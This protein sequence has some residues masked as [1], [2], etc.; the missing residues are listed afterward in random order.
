MNSLLARQLRRLGLNPATPPADPETWQRLIERI[1][2][3]YDDAEQSRYLL[4]RSLQISSREMQDLYEALQR[5]SAAHADEQEHRL[6]AVFDSLSDG[7]CTLDLGGRVEFANA[8]AAWMLGAPQ[9]D[10]IGRG[11]LDAFTFHAG[12][13]GA[14]PA[15]VLRTVAAGDRFLDDTALLSTPAGE[16]VPVSCVLNPIGDGDPVR[17]IVFLFRDL[18]ER[19][20]AADAIRRSEHHYQTLFHGLPIAVYEEDFSRVGA[21]LRWLRERGV[22]DLRAYLAENREALRNAISLIQVRDV[23]PAVVELLEADNAQQLIGPL[24]PAVFTEETL[25]SMQEQLLAIWED[26]DS[27][28]LE[29]TGTTLQGNRLDA[30]FH[31][32]VGRVGGKLDLSK[33][34]VA[35]TDITHRKE[36]EEQMAT[37]VRSKDEFLASVSHELRTPLTAVHGSAEVLREQWP[38]LAEEE[39]TELVGFIAR[40]SQELAHIVEDLLVAARADVGRL[41]VVP[42]EIDVHRE[43][44]AV[45]A[46]VTG[47]AGPPIDIG[48]V[49]G[50]ARADPLRFRQIVRNLLTNALRYGGEEVVIRSD[51][52]NGELLLQVCDDGPGIP[53]SEREAIFQPYHRAH[54]TRGLPGS[55]GLGLTVSRQL[56]MLMEG[57]LVYRHAEGMSTFELRLPAVERARTTPAP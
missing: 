44:A 13:A 56:A 24:N 3:S 37:L 17:G 52:V 18:S 2:K 49:T 51:L 47:S 11:I 1:G 32:S 21:W 5:S 38:E 12:L 36:I 15:N 41:S 30:I 39:R 53:E 10:L 42:E 20:Q 57:D 25:I 6:R 16:E 31:W 54:T 33:V 40:E 28:D 48:G 22:K 50:R 43:V 7:L 29:L 8:A 35:V 45:L 4:E 14:S 34:L 27:V 26:R 19:K 9:R 23:N 55:V 46:A